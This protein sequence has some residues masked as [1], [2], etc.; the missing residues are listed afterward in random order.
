[1]NSNGIDEPMTRFTPVLSAVQA[2]IFTRWLLKLWHC[3]IGSNMLPKG[4]VS[5]LHH[6]NWWCIMVH[7]VLC[8]HRSPLFHYLCHIGDLPQ[9]FVKG[10]VVQTGPCK[11]AKWKGILMSSKCCLQHLQEMD[12]LLDFAS[13]SFKKT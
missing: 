11:Q 2:A 4:D 3:A 10:T 6:F 8:Y 9:S 13:S 5:I 7:Y 12:E 1:M